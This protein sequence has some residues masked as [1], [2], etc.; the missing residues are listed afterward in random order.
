MTGI[1]PSSVF[2]AMGSTHLHPTRA[3]T[4]PRHSTHMG[5]N[6]ANQFP[7]ERTFATPTRWGGMGAN[8]SVPGAT[9]V[10]PFKALAGHGAGAV[11]DV[12]AHAG[13]LLSGAEDGAV[14]VWGAED[15]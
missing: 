15:E 9:T 14:G 2:Q 10:R 12:R 8:P 1:S 11:F 7:P 6:Y 13:I 5:T 4:L 3:P